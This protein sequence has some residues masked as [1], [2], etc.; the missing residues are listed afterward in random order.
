MS[1]VVLTGGVGG[2]KLVLGL[3]Q[4]VPAADLTAIVNTGD[5]F[6]HFGLAISPDIDT[7]LYTL[8]GKSNTELGWGR[9]GESWNFMAALRTLGAP[10]WFNLG[11]GDLAL[12]VLRSARL[13]AGEPLS[14]IIADFA[15]KWDIGLSVL[16]MTDDAVATRL[17]T[18]A[19]LLDFQD[20]FVRLRCVPAT[21]AIRFDGA[22]VAKPAPGVVDAIMG[23]SAI[24]I[25]PSN[26]FLSV[27]PILAVPAIRAALAETKAPVVA[28]SPIVGGAAVKGPTAK[29]MGE[30]G[31]TVSASAVAAHYGDL[32]D[33][34]LV[35]ER[36]PPEEIGGVAVARADTLMHDL[37]DRIRVA[38][39]VL[40]LAESLA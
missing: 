15:A 38:R 3:A 30:L 37:D 21:S 32:L 1:V 9:A 31:L 4:I 13:A 5:D 16:P 2:A 7:L 29:L 24:V 20:Y 36:D 12:H 8:S 18:D 14:A 17:E 28:V 40:A 26:P 11:D 34:L 23:A 10:D 33:G 25:A 6:R 27:D 35:D 22:D 39:A 19:G